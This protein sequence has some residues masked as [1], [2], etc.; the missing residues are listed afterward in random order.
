[1][2]DNYA[3]VFA[4]VF[5]SPLALGITAISILF[6]SRTL[7]YSTEEMV[8]CETH[9]GWEVQVRDN[10]A[11][12]E[13]AEFEIT[14]GNAEKGRY[15]IQTVSP[16]EVTLGDGITLANKNLK[17]AYPSIIP[18]LKARIRHYHHCS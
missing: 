4:A 3:K 10:K 2:D 17:D 1:M 8:F 14:K 16:L 12:F 9:K 15:T 7:S 5:F 6:L 11:M 18:S 13:G